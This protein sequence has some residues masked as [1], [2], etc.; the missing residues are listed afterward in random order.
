[1]EMAGLRGSSEVMGVEDPAAAEFSQRLLG[2]QSLWVIFTENP[3]AM[4]QNVRVPGLGF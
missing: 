3:A 1:M 4:V 2:G